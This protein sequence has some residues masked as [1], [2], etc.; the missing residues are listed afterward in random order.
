LAEENKRENEIMSIAAQA[1]RES[2]HIADS[3]AKIDL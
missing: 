2:I 3:F 1:V